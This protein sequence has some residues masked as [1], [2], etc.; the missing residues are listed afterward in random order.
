MPFCMS[1]RFPRPDMPGCNEFLFSASNLQQHRGR[2][3]CGFSL[4][5]VLWPPM[6]ARYSGEP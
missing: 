2:P 5:P 6:L 3:A 4:S 1:G